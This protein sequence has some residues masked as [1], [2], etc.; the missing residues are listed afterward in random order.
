MLKKNE[1]I[2]SVASLSFNFV[3]HYMLL[4]NSILAKIRFNL[5]V[6]AC[7]VSEI[8][9]FVKR[10]K[11]FPSHA[12]KQK[13]CCKTIFFHFCL[14]FFHNFL[15]FTTSKNEI[16]ILIV[17]LHVNKKQINKYIGLQNLFKI[18]LVFHNF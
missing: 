13:T 4:I 5:K 11:S 16:N 10:N 3:T 17:V 9:Y 8:L 7:Y 15:L 14:R 2:V 1:I 18:S 12:S 6:S